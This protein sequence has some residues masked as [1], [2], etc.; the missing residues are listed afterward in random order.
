MNLP[1]P[2]FSKVFRCYLGKII[3]HSKLNMDDLFRQRWPWVNGNYFLDSLLSSGTLE[4]VI[5]QCWRNGTSF[6]TKLWNLADFCSSEIMHSFDW[7]FWPLIL[8][9]IKLSAHLNL[10]ASGAGQTMTLFG[11]LIWKSSQLGKWLQ[12][13]FF[14]LWGWEDLCLDT[15]ELSLLWFSK[16]NTLVLLVASL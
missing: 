14:W 2:K 3:Y 5:I 15:F 4:W 10:R 11:K 12:S 6:S 13:W 16:I 9:K 8:G 1:S 7:V